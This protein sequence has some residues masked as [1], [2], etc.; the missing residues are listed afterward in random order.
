MVLPE[1]AGIGADPAWR[2][3]HASVGNLLA[4]GVWPTMIAARDGAAAALGEQL[5]AVSVDQCR[6][7]AVEFSLFAVDLVDPFED[8]ASDPDPWAAG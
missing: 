6:E 4:P 5:W 1:L 8:R 7:L 2:A 3:K